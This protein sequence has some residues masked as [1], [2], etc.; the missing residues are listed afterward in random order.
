ML[1]KIAPL[2][3]WLDLGII[4]AMLVATT[5]IGLFYGFFARSYKK[6]TGEFLLGSRRMLVVPVA[7]SMISK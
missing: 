5:A 7:L 2:L 3:D 1:E 4:A 6:T